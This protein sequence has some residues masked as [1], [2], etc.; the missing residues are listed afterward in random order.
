M[1]IGIAGIHTGIGKTVCSAVI[2]QALGF[3]YWK[4][5]QA[6]EL[7]N[8][9]SM[10]IQKLVANPNCKV[11]PERYRLSKPASPHY[12]AALENIS[13]KRDDFE[14]PR[15][16]NHLLLETAGGLM[17]PL[18]TG[19][20]NIDLLEYLNIPVVLVSNNY[21]GSINH[22]LLSC[23]AL[24]RRNLRVPGLVFVGDTVAS[25]EKFI[26][27]HTGLPKLFSVP[28]FNTLDRET[29]E[30]FAVPEKIKIAFP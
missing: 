16:E 4:P 27:N 9:D 19:L 23:E 28:L 15:T 17:S 24:I 3:D 18:N 25:S 29:I 6:G 20:L 12:A 21:L 7:E 8:T 22:T 13:I 5:V 10:L 2:C 1:T 11:H 26:L 14:L 30:E